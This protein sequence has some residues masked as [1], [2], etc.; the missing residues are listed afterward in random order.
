[1]F[2]LIENERGKETEGKRGKKKRKK[3]EKRNKILW[4]VSAVRN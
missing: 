4:V 2:G 1:M 3:K